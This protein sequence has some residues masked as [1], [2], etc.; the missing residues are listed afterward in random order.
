MAGCSIEDAFPDIAGESGRVARKEERRKAKRCGGPALAFLKAGGE[1]NHLGN[2]VDVDPDRQHLNP[3]PPAEK[4][5]KEEGFTS[6]QQPSNCQWLPQKI[7]INEAKVL[8]NKE[9]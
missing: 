5:G 2:E 3:L 6:D 8:L 7:D 4:L 1:G 9:I